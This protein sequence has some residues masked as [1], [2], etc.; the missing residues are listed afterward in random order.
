MEKNNQIT[1]KMAI[2]VG[3]SDIGKKFLE[4]CV[5]K[6]GGK[7]DLFHWIKLDND[8]LI[9]LAGEFLKQTNESLGQSNKRYSDLIR[10]DDLR[11]L[12]VEYSIG[13][14]LIGIE[15][16]FE[17]LEFCLLPEA[18]IDEDRIVLGQCFARKMS[19]LFAVL[20]RSEQELE[21]DR[22]RNEALFKKK[23]DIDWES[24]SNYFIFER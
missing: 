17:S 24:S 9:S 15:Y 1:L 22:L 21:R 19:Q 5:T 18:E 12:K 4:F 2:P 16:V 8:T 13:G 7:S 3:C 10:R 6:F 20:N 11:P 14:S 23:Y